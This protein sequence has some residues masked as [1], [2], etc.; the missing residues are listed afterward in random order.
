MADR[1]PH[2]AVLTGDRRA[3]LVLAGVGGVAELTAFALLESL[4]VY[5]G[6]APYLSAHPLAAVA[7]L[8]GPALVALRGGGLLAAWWVDYPLGVLLFLETYSTGFVATPLGP[9]PMAL[10]VAL[11]PGF[12][13]GSVGYALGRTVSRLLAAEDRPGVDAGNH[14]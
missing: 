14:L 12:L 3:S 2:A 5:Y 8:A 11:V 1:G 6:A 10:L 13:W 7:L 9:L 4:G